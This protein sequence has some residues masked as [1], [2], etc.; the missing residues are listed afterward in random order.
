[1][2]GY[3]VMA[4]SLDQQRNASHSLVAVSVTDSTGQPV[5]NLDR[6]SFTALDITTGASIAISE[7]QSAGV[8]GFYR[9]SLQTESGGNAREFIVALVVAGRHQEA[10][11]IPQ[12]L[13]EGQTLVK[14]RMV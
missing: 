13:N 1:M 14:M 2:A 9:L 6:S 4:L 5:A 12:L 10:G 7:L 3:T 8:R 11:R